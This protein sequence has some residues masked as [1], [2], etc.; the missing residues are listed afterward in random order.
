MGAWMMMM[1]GEMLYVME[2]VI[3]CRFVTMKMD[4][5]IIT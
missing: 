4:G 2:T 5:D 1:S 3:K